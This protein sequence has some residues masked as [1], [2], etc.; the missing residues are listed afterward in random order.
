MSGEQRG[1]EFQQVYQSH[2]YD[3]VCELQ[4]SFYHHRSLFTQHQAEGSGTQPRPLQTGGIG[5][6]Q[7]CLCITKSLPSGREPKPST[8]EADTLPLP[9]THWH[10]CQLLQHLWW[11]EKWDLHLCSSFTA[12]HTTSASVNFHNSI[13]YTFMIKSLLIFCIFDDSF[14]PS[15]QGKRFWMNSKVLDNSVSIAQVWCINQS[16]HYQE[17][18]RSG[19][20]DHKVTFNE[21]FHR[22]VVNWIT[23]AVPEE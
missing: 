9:K 8:W 5:N 12:G 7:T 18:S 23:V 17:G 11:S 19:E 13:F 14:P 3:A 15:R 20:A 10:L 16:K 22:Q 1:R 6:G 2:N 21:N 4:L